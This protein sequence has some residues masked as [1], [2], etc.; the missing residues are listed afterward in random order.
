MIVNK[1]LDHALATIHMHL[2]NLLSAIYLQI[3]RIKS[4]ARASTYLLVIAIKHNNVK[5]GPHLCVIVAFVVLSGCSPN[6]PSK[7]VANSPLA[8]SNDGAWCWFQDPR[9]VYV[10]G[11]RK[12]TY[13][14]WMT[15]NGKLQI[16]AYDH[17]TGHIEVVTLKE[18]WGIDDHNSNSFLVLPDKR[19]MV[20]YARHNETGLFSQT[21]LMPE[22]ISKWDDEITVAN[23]P[24]ITYSNP[25]YL[26]EEG[27]FYVFW[28]GESWK[29]TFSTSTNGK[30]WTP[31]Q[32]LV[33]DN[34]RENRS[35][36]PYLKVVSDGK[37]EIHF[38]FTDGHPSNEPENSIYYMKYK[39]GEFFKADGKRIG[40]MD[41]LPIQHSHSDIV[42][43]GRINK[44]RAWVWDIALDKK[45]S[46][47]IAYTRF[48]R[49]TDHRYHYAYWNGDA[50]F[51]TEI[52]PGGKWFPQTPMFSSETEPYYSGGIAIDHSDPS[53]LYVSRQINQT[54]EIEK[55]ATD[56]Q[57]KNWSVT[58]ITS[59][60]ARNN[61]RPAVPRGY[62]GKNGHVLWMQG[63]YV[64]YTN[65]HT[66]IQLLAPL[67]VDRAQQIAPADATK[68]RH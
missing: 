42:Y 26:S 11:Q 65:Y 68:P 28:R 37:S 54:F 44:V 39:K 7:E 9:A 12:R 6:S 52:A 66:G 59:N 51:D 60:S 62:E 10:E 4:A 23:T 64:H 58:A 40:S 13:A 1:P 15:S 63:D 50:W 45:G 55:W 36:R 29:P 38:A 43:N 34:H 5:S 67:L 8:F 21:T 33:Q 18:K 30:T 47:V 56:N 19:I 17:D 48:P 31:P 14:G 35:I 32:I 24:H 25:V 20:F 49:E 46:P 53:V 61:V 41:N 22:D 57:G 16:G 2:L 27:L 3:Y